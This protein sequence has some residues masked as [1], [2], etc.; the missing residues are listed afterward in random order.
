MKSINFE[1]LRENL[2]EL[3]DAG[4]FSE[5]YLY[6]DPQS[7]VLKLRYFIEILI[8]YLYRHLNIAYE[9]TW[10]LYDFLKHDIFKNTVDKLILGKFQYTIPY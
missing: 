5:Q 2:P 8:P 4:A 6:S 1:S 9:S 7:S 10:T 3:S